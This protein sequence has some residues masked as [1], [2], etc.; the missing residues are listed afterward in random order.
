MGMRLG[1]RLGMGLGV[2][3]AKGLGM[4]QRSAEDIVG[5]GVADETQGW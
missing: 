3:W 5:D 4:G 2:E 1:I